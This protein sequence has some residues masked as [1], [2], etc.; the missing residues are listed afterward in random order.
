MKLA[1]EELLWKLYGMIEINL[2]AKQ[3]VEEAWNKRTEF[4]ASGQLLW[5]ETICPWKE[6]LFQIEKAND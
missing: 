2:P 4:H 1:E 3:I 6:N 5:F